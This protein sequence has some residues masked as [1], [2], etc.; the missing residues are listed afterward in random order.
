MVQLM[1]Q[2]EE[3]DDV[4]FDVGMGQTTAN[5]LEDML[6]NILTV[7]IGPFAGDECYKTGTVCGQQISILTVNPIPEEH[8]GAYLEVELPTPYEFAFYQC[9]AWLE[10]EELLCQAVGPRQ[11]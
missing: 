11:L 2:Q 3:S 1:L 7:S 5:D 4:S 9:K 8:T 10:F 6:P